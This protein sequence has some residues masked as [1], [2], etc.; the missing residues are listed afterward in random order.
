MSYLN[1]I[2][3]LTKEIEI[4]KKQ[5]QPSGTGHLYTTISVLKHEIEKEL[6]NANSIDSS[7]F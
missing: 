5:I 6:K 2:E 1:R 3:F 4:L 7:S